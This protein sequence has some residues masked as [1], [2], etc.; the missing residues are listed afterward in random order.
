MMIQIDPYRWSWPRA[1]LTQVRLWCVAA[2]SGNRIVDHF[3]K[4]RRSL[5]LADGRAHIYVHLGSQTINGTRARRRSFLKKRAKGDR[6]ERRASSYNTPETRNLR[7]I[8]ATNGM[9]TIRY[10]R[11]WPR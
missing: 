5:M 10:W 11:R 3:R 1:A 9:M 2:R 6:Y 7:G 4:C 8:V